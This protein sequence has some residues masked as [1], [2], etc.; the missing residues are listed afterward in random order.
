ML[1]R[2][3]KEFACASKTC[4]I[5][6][7]KS[8]AYTDMA[9]SEAA[10]NSVEAEYKVFNE[11]GTDEDLVMLY[12]EAQ[13]GFVGKIVASIKKIGE[14]IAEFFKKIKTKIIEIFSKK[15]VED[16]IDKMEKKIKLNP[17]A[18]NKKIEINDDDEA[19]GLCRKFMDK[20]KA[21]ISKIKGGDNVSMDEI[22][23]AHES[24]IKKHAL[25][26][27]AVTT[28]TVTAAIALIRKRFKAVSQEAKA[29]ESNAQSTIDSAEE[30]V[31]KVDPEAA[32][33]LQKLAS[34]AA[35]VTKMSASAIVQAPVAILSKIKQKL[36]STEA[37]NPDKAEEGKDEM[38]TNSAKDEFDSEWDAFTEYANAFSM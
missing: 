10:I 4:D 32:S 1:N 33:K 29:D 15:E 19:K 38:D 22:E 28:I 12:E 7:M 13:E 2:I 16:N 11:S 17:F 36:S 8:D 30:A 27:A 3:V 18:R 23:E 34:L 20:I 9:I 21:F 5:T 31:K 6:L 14:A 24:F 25:A 26:V 35:K 37:E